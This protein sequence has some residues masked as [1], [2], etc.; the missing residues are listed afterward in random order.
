MKVFRMMMAAVLVLTTGFLFANG[1][2]ETDETSAELTMMINFSADSPVSAVLEEVI[3]EFN[4]SQDGITVELVPP[5]GDYE[6][7]MKTKMAA[8]D[9]PD[10]FTTHGWSVARYSDYLTPLENEVWA[11]KISPAIK[12]VITDSEGHIYVIPLDADVSG[13]A[14]NKTVTDAAGV[15]VDKIKTWDDLFDAMEKVKK[16][17]VDPVHIGG[18]DNWTIGNFFDW[19]APSVFIT[20]KNN[21]SADELLSG[22]FDT[23]KWE[24]VAGFMKK[25]K[26]NGYLNVDNLTSTWA[27]TQM[28][29]GN[30]ESAFEFFG[31]YVSVG[32]KE[33]NPDA[34][35]GFFPVPAYYDGDVP[36]FITGEKTAI[37]IWKDS[38]NGAAAKE[39]LEFLAQPEISSRIATSN[40]TPAGL[41]DASSDMGD[42]TIYAEKY[43]STPGYPY[44]DR[45]YLPSGM[46]DTMC[47][48]GAGIL[49][50]GMTIE[51]A[52]NQMLADFNSKK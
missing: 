36:T 11:E 39:F 21:S 51:E 43:A 27:D 15:D 40:A 5:A 30:G 9:L 41:T 13:I 4:Q 42:L 8:N 22:T 3:S 24:I 34:D 7:V 52:A 32:G 16:S 50:G 25:M 49:S 18:K 2:Q 14:F 6:Q 23:E 28:A 19:A 38:P 12:P 46:W 17:G 29:F 48:T 1:Q 33:T 35:L 44:F 20:D 45:A 31:N 37:G 47:I 26:D 10:L